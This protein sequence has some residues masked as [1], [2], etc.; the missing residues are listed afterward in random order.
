MKFNIFVDDKRDADSNEG[1]VPAGHEHYGNAEDG[2]EYGQGPVVELEAWPPVWRLEEGEESAG[3]IDEAVAHQE[4]HTEERG[5]SIHV[6]DENSNLCN[7]K[8]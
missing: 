7:E 6:T 5:D 1:K 4:E 2:S 3:H 8:V